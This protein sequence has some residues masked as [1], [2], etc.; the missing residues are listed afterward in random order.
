MTARTGIDL[1]PYQGV[2]VSQSEEAVVQGDHF[3]VTS[4]T[5]TGK[6]VMIAALVWRLTERYGLRCHIVTPKDEIRTELVKWL[7]RAG[8]G[9]GAAKA[10]VYTPQSYNNKLVRAAAGK[11]GGLD[12][13]DVLV[14]DEAHHQLAD[15]WRRPLEMAAAR[16]LRLVLVAFT[17]TPFRGDDDETVEWRQYFKR[18][19]EA[20]TLA[21]AITQGYLVDFYVDRE[22][23]DMLEVGGSGEAGQQAVA[24][25]VAEVRV[26]QRLGRIYDLVQAR[27]KVRTRR[28]IF[29]MPTTASAMAIVQ[30]FNLRRPGLCEYV[31]KEVRSR[32]A[33]K[34]T[35]ERFHNGQCWLV[36]VGVVTEGIDLPSAARIVC[37]RRSSALNPYAQLIGRGLR[38]WRD[39][40]GGPL[41]HLKRDCEVLDLTDNFPRFRPKIL[42]HLGLKFAD[43]ANVWAPDLTW[44]EGRTSLS[45]AEDRVAWRFRPAESRRV[46]G[47]LDGQVVSG[48][49][50]RSSRS[51]NWAIELDTPEGRD[52]WAL[53]S[54][55]WQPAPS[56]LVRPLEVQVTIDGRND[57]ALSVGTMIG[58]GVMAPPV[59]NVGAGY[60]LFSTLLHSLKISKTADNLAPSGKNLSAVRQVQKSQPT[61]E[62]A[63]DALPPEVTRFLESFPKPDYVARAIKRT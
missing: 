25:A 35:F 23:I 61:S 54:G 22:S 48:L 15:T 53:A 39:E 46:V 28:T 40:A 24:D 58:R 47:E 20:I 11:K 6:S 42:T 37:G 21:D 62:N 49:V 1:F 30:G 41:W 12:L 33:R 13:P 2:A 36:G 38:V 4:P 55:R 14:S 50:G 57:L 59:D 51:D 9:P 44:R 56:V 5:G 18:H 19:M 7:V 45:V 34:E 63:A 43:H 60:L 26:S 52:V 8:F 10:L 32:R 27:E 17:A 31:G 16:R 29:A 3:L